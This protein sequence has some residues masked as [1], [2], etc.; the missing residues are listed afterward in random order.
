MTKPARPAEAP[1]GTDDESVAEKDPEMVAFGKR[2]L[3][4]RKE[5]DLTQEGLAHAADLHWTYIGQVE[6]GERNLSYK[7]VLRLA[8][9]LGVEPARLVQ[10][11]VPQ[12]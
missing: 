8:R 6:R 3:A 12:R 5:A 10:D 4:L 2:L 11:D 9:G 1:A 7:N